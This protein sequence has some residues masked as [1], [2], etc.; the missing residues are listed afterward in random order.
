METVKRIYSVLGIE[1]RSKEDY[2]NPL[3]CQHLFDQVNVWD[4]RDRCWGDLY[5]RILLYIYVCDYTLH[6]AEFCVSE[7]LFFYSSDKWHTSCKSQRLCTQSWGQNVWWLSY[8]NSWLHNVG[9]VRQ[10]RQVREM[11]LRKLQGYVSL[12]MCT[13]FYVV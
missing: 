4:L 5:K 11:Y 10:V 13:S 8:C 1:R 12:S 3:L 9:Q 7:R 2:F 6:T